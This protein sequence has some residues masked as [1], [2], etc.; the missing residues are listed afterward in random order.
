MPSHDKPE[1]RKAPRHDW[2][3]AE[4]VNGTVHASKKIQLPQAAGL[5]F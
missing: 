4:N 5:V 3:G 2:W 1:Q